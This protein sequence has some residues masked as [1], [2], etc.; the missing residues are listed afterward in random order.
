MTYTITGS[1][2]YS[3]FTSRHIQGSITTDPN[4]IYYLPCD[5]EYKNPNEIEDWIIRTASQIE[6]DRMQILINSNNRSS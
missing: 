5:G 2:L 1:K 3:Y 4:E 6:S